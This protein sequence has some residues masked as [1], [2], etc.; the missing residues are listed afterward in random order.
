MNI[1]FLSSS[2]FKNEE[3]LES[4]VLAI[5]EVPVLSI[6]ER[7]NDNGGQTAGFSQELRPNGQLS[8]QV[9]AMSHDDDDHE[10]HAEETDHSVM[11]KVGGKV[12]EG[13]VKIFDQLIGGEKE[14]NSSKDLLSQWP[15]FHQH[16][17]QPAHLLRTL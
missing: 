17:L 16:I 15:L 8:F 7:I 6:Q 10:E 4:K 14:C 3:Y 12:K 5:A 9:L 13:W 1:N 2:I 11:V